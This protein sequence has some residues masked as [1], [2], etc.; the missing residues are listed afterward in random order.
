[1]WKGCSSRAKSPQFLAT[2]LQ[3]KT[4]SHHQ[5]KVIGSNQIISAASVSV[6][7][8]FPTLV[9]VISPSGNLERQCVF[10]LCAVLIPRASYSPTPLPRPIFKGLLYCQPLS[11]GA[12]LHPQICPS[13]YA[14][15]RCQSSQSTPKHRNLIGLKHVSMAVTSIWISSDIWCVF[16]ASSHQT[17]KP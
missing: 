16:N 15:W 17:S 12:W 7:W 4:Y 5:T 10:P 8:G 2:T 1:M 11:P 13:N 3:W 14:G 6:Y 9:L